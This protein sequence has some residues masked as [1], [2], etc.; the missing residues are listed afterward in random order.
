MYLEVWQPAAAM[1]SCSETASFCLRAAIYLHKVS[2]K[3][4][5][6]RA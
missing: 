4:R 3:Q 6:G 1:M 5:E 2:Q